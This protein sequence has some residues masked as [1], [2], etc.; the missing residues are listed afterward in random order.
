[1]VIYH[2]DRSGVFLAAGEAR[3]S[4]AAGFNP[5]GS[6]A[7]WIIPANAT[8]TQP[9]A[10]GAG[11]VAVFNETTKSWSVIEDHR[12]DIIWKTSDMGR[13]VML[14]L[15]PIPDGWTTLQ[16]QD[17]FQVWDGTKWV[18][19]VAKLETYARTERTAKLFACDWTQLA[20]SPLTEEEKT[21]WAVYRQ[22]LR[23]YMTGWLPGKPW[24]VAPS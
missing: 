15:G 17:A 4:P 8:T 6:P 7:A 18:Q 13:G 9:P 3:L 14:D 16:P 12:G 5:D 23:D 2:Y 21:A 22:E 24:P 1:M 10:S 11:E 19:D 20:D